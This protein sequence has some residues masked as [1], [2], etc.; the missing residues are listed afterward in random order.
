MSKNEL[1]KVKTLSTNQNFKFD[2]FKAHEEVFLLNQ[3]LGGQPWIVNEIVETTPIVV[4]GCVFQQLQGDRFLVTFTFSWNK[5]FTK[6]ITKM[7]IV[8]DCNHEGLQSDLADFFSKCSKSLLSKLAI[9]KL[10]YSALIYVQICE[11]KKLFSLFDNEVRLY[12][13]LN[14]KKNH[15]RLLETFKHSISSF[16]QISLVAVECIQREDISLFPSSRSVDSVDKTNVDYYSDFNQY[17]LSRAYLLATSPECLSMNF[18]NNTRFLLVSRNSYQFTSQAINVIKEESVN[19]YNIFHSV[20]INE[21][22]VK[23][24]VL[25]NTILYGCV[26][27]ENI[28][29]Y[30]CLPVALKLSK[31]AAYKLNSD[32]G[33]ITSE[34]TLTFNRYSGPG[35]LT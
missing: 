8:E 17:N 33:A 34:D 6:Y 7:M 21:A 31:Q 32:L 25:T 27:Y 14:H 3:I 2:C 29:S 10:E 28:D 9:E 35:Q 1:F 30:V 5:N 23:K 22:N 20:S 26:D 16:G 13:E 19:E 24:W 11:Q 12:E 18:N 4:A 15:A